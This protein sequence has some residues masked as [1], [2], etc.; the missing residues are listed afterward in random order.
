MSNHLTR[1]EFDHFLEDLVLAEA[2]EFAESIKSGSRVKS[3]EEISA[4]VFLHA[5]KSSARMTAIILDKYGLLQ[6]DD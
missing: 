4:E 1:D 2:R 3:N 5:L 6:F